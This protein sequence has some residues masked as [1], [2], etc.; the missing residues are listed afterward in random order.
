MNRAQRRRHALTWALLAPVL[1]VLAA[2]AVFT[3]APAPTGTPTAEV[4]P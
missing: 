3:R 1:V 4:G 2:L